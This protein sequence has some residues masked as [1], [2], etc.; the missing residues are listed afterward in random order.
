MTWFN[1]R[2]YP[3]TN[4]YFIYLFQSLN[5]HWQG[6]LFLL[7]G[8]GLI[9]SVFLGQSVLYLQIRSKPEF[10]LPSNLI[11][12]QG[13]PYALISLAVSLLGTLLSIFGILL[14]LRNYIDKI[15]QQVN[16]CYKSRNKNKRIPLVLIPY[17]LA[18]SYL[19][20]ILFSSNTIIYR[21]ESFSDLY[22]VQIPSSYLLSC[23]GSPGSYPVMTVYLSEN[24]GLMLTPI[25]FVLC[26]FLPLMT[27]LNIL[28]IALNKR[29]PKNKSNNTSCRM[30]G[31]FGGC[32]GLLSACPSCA[33]TI[34]VYLSTVLLGTS[35]AF[36]LL[37][38]ELFQ[39]ILISVSMLSLLYSSLTLGEYAKPAVAVKS[40]TISK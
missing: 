8:L 12:S 18:I 26:G 35:V 29:S 3:I 11:G 34:L 31:I 40:T 5:R 16:F 24:I 33:G 19:V 2:R 22:G 17:I 14:I 13:Q 9:L 15:K 27:G 10:L 4:N 38:N 32:A 23:C 30:V 20:L 6:S 21:S 39:I 36:S 7:L 37:Y 1:Q 25:G 28:L